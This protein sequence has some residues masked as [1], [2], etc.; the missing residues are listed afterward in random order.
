MQTHKP[1][2]PPRPAVRPFM[3]TT[4]GGRTGDLEPDTA[5]LHTM[6]DKAT[7][8]TIVFVPLIL[9]DIPK[10]GKPY[11]N[12][13]NEQII[14][15]I[16]AE[17]RVNQC[18]IEHP[19]FPGVTISMFARATLKGL[20]RE[21][22]LENWNMAQSADSE[23][24]MLEYDPIT[25]RYKARVADSTDDITTTGSFD[26]KPPEHGQQAGQV[27]NR[28]MSPQRTQHQPKAIML[29]QPAF[30]IKPPSA[31]RNLVQTSESSTR[32]SP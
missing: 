11:T 12:W 31:Q 32:C 5:L 3:E 13:N 28:Q 4:I 14:D 27:T 10:P 20:S 29:D 15:Q 19:R 16:I 2:R 7:G 25:E 1:Q 8:R 23:G 9:N 22:V 30:N 26:S 17:T 21:D 24:T 18:T 6:I